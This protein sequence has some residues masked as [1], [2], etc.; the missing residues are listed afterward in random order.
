VS[1]GL[2][3]PPMESPERPA[4]IGDGSH[5]CPDCG[6]AF[7][8][9]STLVD[10]ALTAHV[11][12]ETRAGHI[13]RSRWPWVPRVVGAFGVLLGIG[14]AVLVVLAWAGLFDKESASETPRSVA[15]KIAVELVRTGEADEYRAVEPDGGWDTEYEID[16][17][18]AYIRV[19]G[20]GTGSEE[21]EYEAFTSD[22]EDA[23]DRATAGR[24]F[25][26]E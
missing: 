21:L 3:F 10:H 8:N 2:G 18:D 25:V 11:R 5:T 12:A 15:H 24:G 14:V 19:R 1:Q 17:G 23:L 7:D 26:F 22:L 20:E 6:A 9:P 4:G 16:D 13:R